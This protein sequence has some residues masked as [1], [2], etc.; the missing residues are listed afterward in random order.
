MKTFRVQFTFHHAG[1]Y[2]IFATS[3][4]DAEERAAELFEE[5]DHYAFVEGQGFQVESVSPIRP[6]GKSRGA[7]KATRT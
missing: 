5:G 1:Y 3:S 7:S 6:V 2:D 4:E